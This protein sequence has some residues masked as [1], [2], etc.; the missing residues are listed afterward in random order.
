M[1]AGVALALLAAG[2][3]LPLLH[4]D[5]LWVFTETV[6]L[7]Q[8]I[9]TLYREGETFLGVLLTAFS[10]VFP[11]AKLLGVLWL[12]RRPSPRLAALVDGLGKWSMMDVLVVALL[13]VTLKGSGL[14]TAASA[15]GVYCFAAAVLLSMLSGALVRPPDGRATAPAAE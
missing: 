1:L 14:V 15:P 9:T 7:W 11:A 2:V 13:I 8:A 12:W 3:G 4:I 10:I 6:S 5:R